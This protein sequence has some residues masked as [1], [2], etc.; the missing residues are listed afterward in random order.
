MADADSD[1]LE[2]PSVPL[3]MENMIS[4]IGL[5]GLSATG[6]RVTI[7][8]ALGVPAIW[9]AVN[10]LSGTLAA[11]PLNLFRRTRAG[12][13][14][15]SGE[16]SRL[17][18]DN[19]NDSCTSFAWR[20]YCFEQVFTG[21]RSYTFIERSAAGKIINLWPLD[22][23]RVKVRRHGGR[24]T[25]HLS[26]NG[27]AVSYEAGE[28]IDLAF[29]L[30]EDGVAHRSPILT[31]RDVVGLA[32]AVTKYGA[33]F[34]R[35]GGVPPFAITGPF[36][37]PGGVKRSSDNLSQ[38]VEE[39]AEKRKLALALPPGHDVKPL[40]ELPDQAG[41]VQL[42]RFINEDVARIYSFP[43][44]FLQDLTNGTFANTEQQDLQ[45]VKH[46]LTRWAKQ[47]E[48][49]TTLKLFGRKNAR[50][51]VE[52]NLDGL[53]RG[54]F[55]TRMEGNARAIQSGQITPDEARE[56]ENMPAMGG[57]AA[58]LHMQGAMLPI[59]MLGKVKPAAKAKSEENDGEGI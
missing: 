25:Y 59:D 10:F 37:S 1:N 9:A 30:R 3:T 42:K 22:P 49:E 31:N 32:Q 16:L 24:V 7:S 4:F 29:M 12:R 38:A 28:I 35:N 46:T 26:E 52:M 54:D 6:E 11:L 43:P 55:K 20:K 18:H 15:E 19:V 56:R 27:R 36:T 53:L 41:I 39:A 13:E 21:G 23:R 58:Q 33:K 48:Q 8:S 50:L 2:N 45:L 5:E 57:A 40:G 51:Y 14:K 47:F 44:V 34:F 17:L